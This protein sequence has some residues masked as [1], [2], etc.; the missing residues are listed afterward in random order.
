MNPP[1]TQVPRR[2]IPNTG[3]GLRIL[4]AEDGG[5]CAESMALLLRLYGHEVEVARD[6]PA[7]VAKAQAYQPDVL[8]L[9]IGL[10]GMDGYHVAKR[11]KE[12]NAKKRPFIIAVTGFGMEADRRRS[13][14]SGIDVHW[15]KPVDPEQLQAL[16]VR[17]HGII[18]G[19][20]QPS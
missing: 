15:V 18:A 17:F 3:P 1:S 19:G 2:T 20:N 16:L 5:D 9:D 13:A 12:N 8:L 11:L 6:G 10:P 7:A 4:L 14:E